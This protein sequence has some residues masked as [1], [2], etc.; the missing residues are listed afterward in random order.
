MYVE[1]RQQE[2]LGAT[3]DGMT[4]RISL[5]LPDTL[6]TAIDDAAATRRASPP[7]PGSSGSSSAPCIEA[8]VRKASAAGSPGSQRARRREIMD[9]RLTYPDYV[10][11]DR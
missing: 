8:V 11:A 10:T 3:D 9:F 2:D 4:A 1:E 6:K 5:R 7:T